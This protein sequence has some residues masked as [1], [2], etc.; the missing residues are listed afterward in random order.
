MRILG[1]DLAAKENNITGVCLM[2]NFF[3]KVMTIHTDIEILSVVN[4]F[5]PKLLAV[6]APLS[7]E[8]RKCD[9]MLK[10]YGAMPLKVKSI[11]EL[12]VRAINLVS[13]IKIDKRIKVIEVFPTATAKILRIYDKKFKSRLENL[14]NF[15]ELDSKCLLSDDE[16]DAF[17][18]S[19]TGLLFQKKLAIGVGDSFGKIY[20]PKEDKLSSCY[21]LLKQIE[22][23]V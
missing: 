14:M 1:I 16:F 18:C 10:K 23:E 6:D 17:M 19:F 7:L 2:E 22:I 21:E 20:I 13:E 15:V 5:K 4:E 11:R 9:I 3:C 12:A 8:N